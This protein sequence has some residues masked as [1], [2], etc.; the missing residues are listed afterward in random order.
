[1]HL[2]ER[3]GAQLR[4]GFKRREGFIHYNGDLLCTTCSKLVLD[5][6]CLSTPYTLHCIY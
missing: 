5:K 1:M 4:D 2:I 6:V 3:K